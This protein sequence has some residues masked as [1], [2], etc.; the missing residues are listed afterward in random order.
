MDNLTMDLVHLCQRNKD[1]SY[2][3]QTNRKRG[4]TA[5]ADDLSDLGYKL[6]SAASL[7]PKHIEALVE[8]WLDADTTDASIRNRLTWLRWWAEKV[9]K[10]NVVNR[11]NAAYGVAARGE[12]TRNRAQTLDPAKFKAIECPYIQASLLLQ[13]AFGLRREEAMKFQPQA[14]IRGDHITLQASWTKGGRARTIPITTLE[15]RHVLQHVMKLV[16][17]RGSLIPAELSYVEHLKRFEY[18]T[19]KVNLRNTHGLRHAYAQNRYLV[20]TGQACP[21]GG[22]KDWATMTQ[23]EREADRAARRQISAELGHGRLKITDIYLGSAFQ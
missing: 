15:Q 18:Q 14:A 23:K 21:L 1:G 13:A 10:P 19:L 7:K 4:L 11:D 17:G 6:P 8:K 2:G 16:P 9:N 22:G 12:V 5:M 3:T 20:L